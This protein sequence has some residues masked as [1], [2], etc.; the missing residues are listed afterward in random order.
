MITQVQK[1]RGTAFFA[2]PSVCKVMRT[3]V[4]AF[5]LKIGNT[6]ARKTIHVIDGRIY[7]AKMVREFQRLTHVCEPFAP[8]KLLQERTRLVERQT[9]ESRVQRAWIPVP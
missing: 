5:R 6:R 7:A 2:I 3:S 1:F 8:R 9:R 4:R